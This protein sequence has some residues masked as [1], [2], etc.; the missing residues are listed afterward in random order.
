VVHKTSIH[1]D[2]EI[3]GFTRAA[4]EERVE[5]CELLSLRKSLTRLFRNGEYPP[6]RGT[7]LS[8]DDKTHILYTR[9]SVEFYA[10]YPGM[11]MPRT[12]EISCDRIEQTPKFL[13]EEVLALTKMNWNDTQFDGGMPITIRAARQV[14]DILKYS[15]L[16]EPIPSQYSFYM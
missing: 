11:Y 5:F 16:N 3:S 12:V 4:R 1:N 15:A 2:P 14:G 8:C 7:F 9:G 6:L 10:T 13:A